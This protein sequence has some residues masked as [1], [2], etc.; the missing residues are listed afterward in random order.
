MTFVFICLDKGRPKKAIVE[1][2]ETRGIPF[3]DV[4]MG[5][6]LTKEGTLGGIIR[7][8]TSTPS[9]RA[10][11]HDKDRIG[12]GAKDER[13]EY[14]QNIQIADLNMYNAAQAVIRWKKLFSFYTDLQR[15]HHSTLQL[16]TNEVSNEDDEAA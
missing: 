7:T 6:Y 4:G 3:I 10:H 8:T 15:E 11:V 9:M 14:D 1:A 12:F 16:V 13:N 5:V 2:L